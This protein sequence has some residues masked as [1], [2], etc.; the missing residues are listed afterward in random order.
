MGAEEENQV[1]SLVWCPGQVVTRL[2]TY[3]GD[4]HRC[5]LQ[6]VYTGMCLHLSGQAVSKL[7]WPWAW[8]VLGPSHVSSLPY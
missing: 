4:D 6:R 1:C 7:Y 5:C 8:P 3:H 2:N